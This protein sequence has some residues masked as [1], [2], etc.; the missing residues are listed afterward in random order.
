MQ[1]KILMIDIETAPN[2]AYVWGLFNQNIGINQMVESGRTLCFAAKWLGKKKMTFSS[3]WTD[4]REGMIQHAWDLFEEADIV[5]HYNGAKFDVPTLQREFVLE[6]LTP[7][8]P[9]RQIDL[10]PVVR[11][12]F[13]FTSNKLD[14]VAQQLGLGGKSETGGFALWTG[15]LGEDPK[16]QKVMAKYNKKDVVLLEDLYN[17]LL[18]W[19]VRTPN[20]GVYLD[21]G[22]T[23]CT[24]C[25]SEDIQYRGYVYL[26]AGKYRQFVCNSC[27]GWSREGSN[28]LSAGDRKTL[29]RP[30]G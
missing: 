2:M 26:Q 25:G 11:K 29:A 15:V 27:G 30:I 13:R 9:F 28:L 16:A 3:E 8:S 21:S 20:L 5:C 22:R 6:G 18:P 10:L 7:P 14:Y 19:L 24:K 12:Q 17:E 4:G 1:P 23:S